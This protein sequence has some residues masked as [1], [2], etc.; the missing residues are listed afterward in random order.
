MKKIT[1]AIILLIAVSAFGFVSTQ[2]TND[3]VKAISQSERNS[4]L[5]GADK[6]GYIETNENSW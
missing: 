5:Q 6:S 3:S 4:S 1:L 2:K